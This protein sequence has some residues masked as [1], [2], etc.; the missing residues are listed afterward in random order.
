[1]KKIGL[2]V[3]AVLLTA[4]MVFAAGAQEKK[5]SGEKIELV[6]VTWDGPER[7][8]PYYNALMGVESSFN[9]KHPNVKARYQFIPSDQYL[10][11]IQTMVMAD[12]APDLI[13]HDDFWVSPY[14]LDD[15]V[16]DMSQFIK[17][18]PDSIKG[19]YPSM[20]GYMQW[21]GLQYSIGSCHL[22]LV[23]WYRKDMFR[24][25]GLDRPEKGW[26]WK[27]FTETCRKI[28]KRDADGNTTQ[29][30]YQGGLGEWLFG[31][32]AWGY[33]NGRLP[34]DAKTKQVNLATPEYQEVL[35]FA[36][37]LIY[38]EKV[39]TRV[40]EALA[41]QVG[42]PYQT[43]RVGMVFNGSW[44]LGDP[45]FTGREWGATYLPVNKGKVPLTSN[46]VGWFIHKK[47]K[48]QQEAWELV[49]EFITPKAQEEFTKVGFPAVLPEV[50]ERL[51]F[52]QGS[53]D[54]QDR[55]VFFD[56]MANVNYLGGDSYRVPNMW[57]V[58][59]E[60]LK[61]ESLVLTGAKK[62]QDMQAF[63]PTIAD[64]IK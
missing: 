58:I 18:D 6:F 27:E 64:L 57:K 19:I 13:Y 12:Q 3:L 42:A 46:I 30:A 14:I 23:L 10:A 37:D 20:L 54:D 29:Y 7:H 15:F 45:G 1:M 51:A 35:Q 47:S 43:G 5:P 16:V 36:Y 38:K 56:V 11:K 8:I 44:V 25:A 4:P 2:V 53:L 24:E 48:H 26:T 55:K 28:T 39:A 21:K 59:D 63:A 17:K 31:G 34:I 40:G 49:K 62:P 33:S 50:N 60:Y 61:M 32:M 9:A 52:R 22:P 41:G